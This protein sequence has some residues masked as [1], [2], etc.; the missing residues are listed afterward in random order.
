ME[1]KK[2]KFSAKRYFFLLQSLAMNLIGYW[3]GEE[4]PNKF[5]IAFAI[6]NA[7]FL[8][9]ICVVEF[10]FAYVNSDNLALVLTFKYPTNIR[11]FKNFRIV[12]DCITPTITKLIT[13][14]KIISV[15]YNHRRFK[16]I[17]D[18]LQVLY[19]EERGDKFLAI[20]SKMSKYSYIFTLFIGIFGNATGFFFCS[21]PI[22]KN[23]YFY[24][25]DMPFVPDL[26]FKS[27]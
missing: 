19:M 26:P 2:F 10:N 3:P 24:F 8:F 14:I 4:K 17:L 15:T 18:K 9:F 20:H 22:F 16:T 25:N 11:I 12:L 13:G 21:L 6:F 23:I 27:E 5:K 7:N 1:D